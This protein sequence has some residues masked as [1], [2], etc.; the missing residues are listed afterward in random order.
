MFG[1][2]AGAGFI[3][4]VAA[5][6]DFL[7]HILANSSRL[8]TSVLLEFLAALSIVGIAVMMVPV[9]KRRDQKLA[10][11]YLGLRLAESIFCTIPAVL[12]LALLTLSDQAAS[13]TITI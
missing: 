12:L 10:A 9:M 1:S 4:G 13:V 11:G 5:A 3:E 6:P 8:W 2:L 7:D